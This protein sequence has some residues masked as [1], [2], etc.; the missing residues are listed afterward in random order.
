MALGEF[1]QK[2]SFF[3]RYTYTH[4]KSHSIKCKTFNFSP[5][6]KLLLSSPSKH[7]SLV[8]LEQAMKKVESIIF[9]FSLFYLLSSLCF[10]LF[11]V[12]QGAIRGKRP[13]APGGWY[14]VCCWVSSVMVDAQTL[15]LP[16]V[17]VHVCVRVCSCVCACR[18]VLP[19]QTSV[20]L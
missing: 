15:A 3:F 11:Q 19:T 8:V 18:G 1:R 6:S 13:M 7:I 16:E 2:S 20:L 9:S 4:T 17:H 5:N 14:L 12:G 10:W